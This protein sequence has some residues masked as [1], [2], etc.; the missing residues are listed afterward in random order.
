M[1]RNSKCKDCIYGDVC[2]SLHPCQYF[3]P[4]Y[5]DYQDDIPEKIEATR[6]EY[7]KAFIEYA[8]QYD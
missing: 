1:Q 2:T 5:D 3:V 6:D 4:M 7:R 8:T